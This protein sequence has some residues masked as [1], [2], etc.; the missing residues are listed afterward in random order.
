M[1][2]EVAQDQPVKSD[3]RGQRFYTLSN[4]GLEVLQAEVGR[5]SQDVDL[6]RSILAMST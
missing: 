6:A 3:G 1:I 2:Q 5:L 4:L